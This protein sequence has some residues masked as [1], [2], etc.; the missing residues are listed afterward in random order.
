M[1][2]PH[3]TDPL[4][5]K[6]SLCIFST[7]ELTHLS[8]SFSQ[9]MLIRHQSCVRC[10]GYLASICLS[11]KLFASMESSKNLGGSWSLCCSFYTQILKALPP[12]S[13]KR[14]S[15]RAPRGLLGAEA[16]FLLHNAP[17][18]APPSPE[19]FLNPNP[20]SKSSTPSYNVTHFL[21]I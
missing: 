2:L 11:P 21:L 14:P 4:S 7:T 15:R 3:L 13:P 9:Q 8:H 10:R 12:Q 17:P 20:K 5:S 1:V 19:T 6:E 16:Q 18:L